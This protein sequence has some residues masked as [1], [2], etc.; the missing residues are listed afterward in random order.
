MGGRRGEVEK[1]LRKIFFGGKKEDYIVFVR[2]RTNNGEEYRPLPARFIDDI[3]RGYII[4]GEDMIPF[5]RVVEIR[6]IDGKIVYSRIK[7]KE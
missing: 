5:H 2:F 3:R 1:W 6:S 4:V 7:N